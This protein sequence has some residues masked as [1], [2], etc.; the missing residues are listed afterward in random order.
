MQQ[1]TIYG[2]DIGAG[3]IKA[4]TYLG[5]REGELRRVEQFALTKIPTPKIEP[6]TNGEYFVEAVQEALTPYR[7]SLVQC[8]ADPVIGAS[9]CG[10]VFKNTCLQITNHGIAT[11]FDI[12]C[13]ICL[14]DGMAATIGT[15]MAGAGRGHT[16]ALTCFTIGTGIGHGSIHWDLFGNLVTNDSEAHFA[17]TT[18]NILNTPLPQCACG[19]PECFEAHASERALTAYT[20]AVLSTIV[21]PIKKFGFKLEWALDHASENA[22]QSLLEAIDKWH[23]FLAQGVATAYLFLNMGGN[24]MLP[25]ALFVFGGGLSRFVNP[26][27]VKGYVLGYL[28][29]KPIP[30][31]NFAVKCESDFGDEAGCI[32][33]AAAALAS[34]INRPVTEIQFA[35]E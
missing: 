33:A 35:D 21:A 4:G 1:Y 24:P 34:R 18:R 23:R 15:L 12:P 26:K 22:R 28:A 31:M 17:V 2:I 11:P 20:E 6:G 14:N 19:L 16:G 10:P 9:I 3:T 25:P 32:G 27:K 30:G 5:N 8:D 29:G 7:Y 13:E